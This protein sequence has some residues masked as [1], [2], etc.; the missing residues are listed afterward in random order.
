M[1]SAP[2]IH[3]KIAEIKPSRLVEIAFAPFTG[4][5][6]QKDIAA[7]FHIPYTLPVLACDVAKTAWILTIFFSNAVRYTPAWGRLT[8]RASLLGDKL[9]ISVE[10]SGYG[11]PMERLQRMFERNENFESPEFGQGLA[12]LLAAEI[13][14][15]QQGNIG[16]SSELG[17]MTQFYMDLPIENATEEKK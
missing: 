16:A 4:Q 6:S 9:R 10:N 13:A 2:V 14:E 1:N 8:V 15:A 7:E 11:V 12:L 5:F 3:L 17:V